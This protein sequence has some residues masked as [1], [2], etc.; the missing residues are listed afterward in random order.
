M[1][2][3]DMIQNNK[4]SNCA[5][6]DAP[7][8]FVIMDFIW[9]KFNMEA[10][11]NTKGVENFSIQHGLFYIPDANNRLLFALKWP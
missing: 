11:R 9:A 7:E 6:L 8:L 5:D 10:I 1:K 2:P 3:V 4:Y